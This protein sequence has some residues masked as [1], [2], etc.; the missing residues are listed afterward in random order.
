MGHRHA[1][2]IQIVSFFVLGVGPVLLTVSCPQ[3]RDQAL[4]D[5]GGDLAAHGDHV[6]QRPH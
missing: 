1:A 2:Q 5:L 4:A 3:S 6:E